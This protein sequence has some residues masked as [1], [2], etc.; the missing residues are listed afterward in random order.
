MV[1]HADGRALRGSP[2]SNSAV[3]SVIFPSFWVT[4]SKARTF[5]VDLQ[6]DESPFSQGDSLFD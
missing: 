6:S 5:A 1:P 3:S 4:P 2:I